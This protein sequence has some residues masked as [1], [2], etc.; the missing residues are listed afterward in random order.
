MAVDI[1]ESARKWASMAE[2]KCLN[3]VDKHGTYGRAAKALGCAK[4]T[5]YKAVERAIKRTEDPA[6]VQINE[7]L[8]AGGMGRASDLKHGWKIVKDGD[9]NGYSL[10]FKNP[11]SDEE[12]NFLDM[13]RQAVDEGLDGKAPRYKKPKKPKGERLVLI[14]LS[15]V[16]FLKLC[17]KTETGYEYTRDIARARV[18]EG[19]KAFLRDI[20]HKTI[21]RFLFVLGNDILHVDG[22]KKKTTSGTD[23]DVDGSIFQG[24]TDAHRAMVDAIELCAEVAPVDLIHCMS[25]HDWVV[26]WALTQSIAAHFRNHKNVNATEYAISERHR[27][28]YRYGNNLFGF[29]HGDGA[30]E[31][32]LYGLMVK[33]ARQHVGECKNLY[34]FLHHL[35]HKIRRRRGEEVILTEKDHNG[36]TAIMAGSPH[37]QGDE[38]NIEYVRSPSPPDGWHDR[39]GYVNKQAV[40]CFVFEPNDGMKMRLT[41][42]F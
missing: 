36:V 4:S 6:N 19:V 41:E 12:L 1:P 16:H 42:W 21:G 25:N 17:V 32:K 7:A 27:K 38:I 11:H 35:H 20:D 13:V 2:M 15:D 28:Y 22:P 34:W 18:I 26:G 37:V 39:Q 30:K 29:S 33:E 5:V 31:E 8:E 10:F 14:D 24:F 9:G 3:A 23:Q 40:E